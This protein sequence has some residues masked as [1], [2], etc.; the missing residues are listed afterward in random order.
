[1]F[2]DLIYFSFL[3]VE[4][5]I[6]GI[7]CIIF[8]NRTVI[9]FQCMTKTRYKKRKKQNLDKERNMIERMFNGG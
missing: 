2:R 5:F 4:I 6:S 7:T 9:G 1:M 8:E 3:M